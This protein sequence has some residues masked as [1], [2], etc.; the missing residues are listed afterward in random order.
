MSRIGFQLIN[1]PESVTVTTEK[2][3]VIING[4]KG[5]L[6]INLPGGIKVNSKDQ[7]L[8]VSRTAE[9]TVHKSLHGTIRSLLENAVKGVSS[10][11]EKKLEMVGIGYRAAIDENA[12]VLQVGFT[13]NVRLV[14]PEG[15][16]AKVEKNVI[17][18]NGIDKQRVGQYSAEI[19]DIRPP[20]PYKGK[21]IR[22]SGEIVRM[23][24]GKAVK[25]AA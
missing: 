1:L 16:E 5:Q 20:E 9:D 7:Q 21:G 17:T 23:K 13:H 15:L 2:D 22:Y 6:Q 19:R 8:T 3:Q 4:P 11:F 25:A 10:G 18:I 24:Q 12:L 14:I